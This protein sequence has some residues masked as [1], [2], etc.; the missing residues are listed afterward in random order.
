MRCRFPPADRIEISQPFPA[1]LAQLA[2]IVKK[3]G[4]TRL[5]SPQLAKQQEMPANGEMFIAAAGSGGIAAGQPVALS[6]TDLPHHSVAPRADRAL[7]RAGH[8]GRRRLGGAPADDPEDRGAAR[9]ALIARREK[10]FQELVRLEHDQ[11]R[12]RGDQARYAAR[13]EELIAA[14]EHVY[15]ALDSDDP[16]SRACAAG[17]GPQPRDV[18]FDRVDLVDVSRHFGRR[19]ALSHVSRSP[20]AAA[21]SSA[22][23][24][25]T[26]PASRRS[27]ACWR[28]SSRRRAAESRTAT[29]RRRTRGPGFARASACSR[30]SCTSIRSC[31]R[32]RTWSSSRALYGLDSAHGRSGGARARPA[33]GD[34]GRRRGV[35][36]S[37]GMRQRL[38][39]ERALLHRP[40]LVLFDEPFT[41][42]DDR[43]VGDRVRPAP[44]RSP[45]SGAIVV[46]ATHDLDLAD[47]LVT[48]VALCATAG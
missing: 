28:R 15:G 20:R 23:S 22:C 10:L 46:L 47:G 17:A 30:T 40:R 24:A 36:F 19:R 33:L 42:L 35:G 45:A 34:R 32:G 8:R 31:P 44:A 11:R 26:A 5:S 13:R 6:V 43:A 27:S 21:R 37:R 9:R 39:L 18:D 3:V 14:L 4:D 48:R 1:T 29:G 7:A 12:G 25:R 16:S 41:G 2:V 38:A